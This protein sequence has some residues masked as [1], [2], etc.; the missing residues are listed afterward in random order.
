VGDRGHGPRLRVPALDS[1]VV[2]SRCVRSAVTLG[3]APGGWASSGSGSPRC[4]VAPRPPFCLMTVGHR[5]R[6]SG[7]LGRWV[8]SS[9]ARTGSS[10]TLAVSL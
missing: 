8:A 9:A 5:T 7:G 1:T 3:R 6:G 10:G 2:G 4:S